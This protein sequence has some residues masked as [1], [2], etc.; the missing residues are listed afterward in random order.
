MVDMSILCL[1]AMK[2]VPKCSQEKSKEF[3]YDSKEITFELPQ[4]AAKLTH[5]NRAPVR[6]QV[7][8]RRRG[9]QNVEGILGHAAEL[10]SSHG[11]H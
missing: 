8:H 11:L 1:V 9:A 2:M 3:H 4:V 5:H 10:Q 6:T 7:L